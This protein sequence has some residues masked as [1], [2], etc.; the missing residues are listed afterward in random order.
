[1]SLAGR[2]AAAA[3]VCSALVCVSPA[4]AQTS[5]PPSTTPSVTVGGVIQADYETVTVAD[6]TRDRAF[7][8]RLMLVVQIVATKDW[9]GQLQIDVA[10][11]V[12]GDRV[13]VRDAYLRYLGWT[14]QGLTVT[15]G[16][17]KLPFSRAALISASRRGLIERGA[18]GERPYG[19]PGRALAVQIE[20]RHHDQHVQWAAA[21]ASALHGPDVAEIRIDGLAES[22]E[23]WNEGVLGAGRV[24]WHPLGNTPRDQ[25]DFARG[26]LRVV[27]GA[28]AY[29]WQNDGDRNLF[30]TDGVA[31]STV[32]ADADQA[33]GVEVSGGLRGHGF[34]LD[35]SWQRIAAHTI[36]A[37]FTGGIYEAGDATFHVTGVESGY[38]A[39]PGTR[40]PRWLRYHRHHRAPALAY[41]P[42]FGANWYVNQ[43]RL[44]F[45]F[46]H[47][48]AFNVLGVR[49][50]RGRTTT[51]QAHLYF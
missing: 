12:L 8:R 47:R 37:G 26:P 6:A 24:E 22:R 41:R 14:P 33:Q 30:T 25:G 4:G 44:K 2:T 7:F 9:T 34:S 36:D 38:M 50:V 27:V 16:N 5:P 45:Q 43:H 51:L 20:G 15:I 28:G 40:D 19:T 49:G 39:V 31:T 42:S 29:V 10:P 35:A 1:M 13:V 46:T 3:A 32:F 23:T 21:V 18:P 48:E 11:S 17:Q